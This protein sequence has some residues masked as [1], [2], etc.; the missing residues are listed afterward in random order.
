MLIFK[1]I[2]STECE[3]IQIILRFINV[4]LCLSVYGLSMLIKE[5]RHSSIALLEEML[6]LLTQTV[7]FHHFSFMYPICH[8]FVIVKTS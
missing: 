6:L 7:I 3:F 5:S 1:R 2:I 4:L 8:I